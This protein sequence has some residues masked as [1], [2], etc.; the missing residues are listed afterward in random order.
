MPILRGLI[1]APTL[2][3]D[4]SVIDRPGY[5]PITGLLFLGHDTYWEPILEKPTLQDALCALEKLMIVLE[6]FPFANPESKSAAIA[7]IPTALIRK[8]IATA[9]MIGITAP[10]M[11]SGKSLLADTI[12]LIATGKPNGVLS[13]AENEVEER[14][15]LLL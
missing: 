8:S 15:R 9:P 13:M 7:G 2:R 4:G 3:P 5:D 1:H 14:K 11:G 6:G 10:K 12:A